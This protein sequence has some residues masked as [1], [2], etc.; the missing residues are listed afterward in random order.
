MACNNIE[1]ILFDCGTSTIGGISTIYIADSNDV[2]SSTAVTSAWTVSHTMASG[3]TFEVIEFRKN[4]GSY[5]EDYTRADDGA[6]VYNQTVN[7]VLHGR[8]AAKS[9][10]INIL[11]EGQRLLDII[12]KMNS[13]KY[14]YFKEMQ[15]QTLADGSG[16]TK[17][18]GSKYTI[19][20]LG[21]DEH[22]AYFM[23]EANV[24]AVI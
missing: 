1:E 23:D 22:L 12:V 21:E 16:A 5:T 19:S 7:L 2:V 9:R 3:A 11:G 13:G 8:D 17:V 18:E 20:F 24:L 10:K 6:V 14:V 4:V 15:L